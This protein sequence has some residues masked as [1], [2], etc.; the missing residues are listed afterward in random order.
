MDSKCEQWQRCIRPPH[1]TPCAKRCV[2]RKTSLLRYAAQRE[3]PFRFRTV[4]QLATIGHRAGVAD[5]FGLRL[6]GFPAWCLWRTIY[7]A[8]LP[9]FEK[10]LRVALRWTMDFVF[11]KDLTQHVTLHGIDRVSR[12][13][14]MSVNTR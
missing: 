13:W 10:K 7:L 3:Q 12:Y 1:S 2:A 14:R 4:G 6:S 5:I 8:K 9:T 11:P